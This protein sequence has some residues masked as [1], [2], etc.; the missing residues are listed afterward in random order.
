MDPKW[1]PWNSSLG[2]NE[3][4]QEYLDQHRMRRY[5][6]P[7]YTHP[8]DH[9]EEIARR[10]KRKKRNIRWSRISI[11]F[12]VSKNLTLL[13]I[14]CILCVVSFEDFFLFLFIRTWS[15]NL[16]KF[17][18]PTL[19]RNF[20]EGRAVWYDKYDNTK[21]YAPSCS[22][23]RFLQIRTRVDTDKILSLFSHPLRAGR[24][25]VPYLLVDPS[26]TRR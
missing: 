26:T 21:Y 4:I 16:L 25:T 15:W 22:Y 2:A 20:R 1:Y 18:R 14:N 5:I 13:H 3:R 9:P 23:Y 11:R 7:K 10:L 12:L 24:W 19:L 6:P 17:H 8:K